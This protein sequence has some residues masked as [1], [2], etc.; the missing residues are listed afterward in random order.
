MHISETIHDKLFLIKIM[1]K[2]I[3]HWML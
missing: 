1:W 2:K 3:H